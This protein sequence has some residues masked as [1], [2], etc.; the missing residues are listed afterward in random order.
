MH[1]GGLED[2]LK[3]STA[4][5]ITFTPQLGD[6]RQCGLAICTFH[7]GFSLV[8]SRAEVDLPPLLWPSLK[9]GIL[10]IAP[11][12]NAHPSLKELG[13]T[14]RGARPHFILDF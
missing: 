14:T 4:P 13:H 3:D 6:D 5:H 8:R 11:D 9:N 10:G 12:T 7:L 2:A 1:F